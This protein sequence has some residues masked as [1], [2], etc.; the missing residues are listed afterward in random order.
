MLVSSEPLLLANAVSV[1]ILYAGSYAFKRTPFP[2][3]GLNVCIYFR[4]DLPL[5]PDE[6]LRCSRDWSSTK[7]NN[8]CLSNLRPPHHTI[9]VFL[10]SNVSSLCVS[11][12]SAYLIR[13][14]SKTIH[15]LC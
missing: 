14:I 6:P 15:N 13:D 10:N 12:G 1:D 4:Y 2:D 3:S 5:S 11:F 9:L 8:L 7:V